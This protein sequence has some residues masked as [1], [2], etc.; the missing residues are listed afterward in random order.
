MP[1]IRLDASIDLR[2]RL[3]ILSARTG[4]IYA[5]LMEEMVTDMEKKLDVKK[6]K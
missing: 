3:R 6:T 4:K 1:D 2:R 5:D